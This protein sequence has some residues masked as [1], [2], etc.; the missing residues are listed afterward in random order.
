MPDNQDIIFQ[1]KG[2]LGVITLN[3][4][5]A[6]NALN[7]GMCTALYDQLQVWADDAAIGAVLIKGAGEKAFCAGGDVVS[8][9]H[10]GKA[11]VGGDESSTAWRDFFYAEYRMN[12]AIADFPK[13]YIALMDGFTMGGGVGVSVHGSHRVASENTKLSMPETGLGLIPDVGGGYFMPRLTGKMGMFLA[14]TGMRVKAGD[15]VDMGIC[16]FYVTSAKHEQ[17][18]ASLGA[19]QK[20]DQEVVTRLLNSFS[21][22]P[23]AGVLKEKQALIDDMFAPDSV[24]GI[25]S[26][27]RA[28]GSNWSMGIADNLEKMSPTSLKLTFRQ[29]LLGKDLSMHDDLQ[30][31]FRLVNRILVAHDF[32]EGVRALLVDKDFSPKWNPDKL[33]NVND[34]EIEKYFEELGDLELKF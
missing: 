34:A 32:Y 30:M 22:K 20:L 24:E 6:L 14:L 29:M 19:E 4:P 11:Y 17:L 7:H 5:K 28:E 23:E 26:A 12:A 16:G 15:C 21:E 2:T 10:S 13:P 33:A 25:M 8:L 27:L 18:L 9:Y 1:V 3:R 31:E